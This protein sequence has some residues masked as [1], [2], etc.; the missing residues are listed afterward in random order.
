VGLFWVDGEFVDVNGHRV[1]LDV[2]HARI[3][4]RNEGRAA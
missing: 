2:A 1:N 3:S 4:A